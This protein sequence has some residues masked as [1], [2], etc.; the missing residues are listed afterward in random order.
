MPQRRAPPAKGRASH[1]LRRPPA[2]SSAG[3]RRDPLV[4]VYR[5]WRAWFTR[6]WWKHAQEISLLCLLFTLSGAHDRER[7]EG[8]RRAAC[9]PHLRTSASGQ[10]RPLSERRCG[11]IVA[12]SLPSSPW[13]R[14]TEYTLSKRSELLGRTDPR[15][16]LLLRAPRAGQCWTL[17]WRLHCGG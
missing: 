13:P 8:T 15:W 10:N 12:A 1:P 5:S 11:C 2:R 3:Y 4:P 16:V 7:N 9:S 17:G 14:A 6:V